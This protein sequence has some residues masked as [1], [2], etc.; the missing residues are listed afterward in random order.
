MTKADLSFVYK[1]IYIYLA[2]HSE[3]TKLNRDNRNHYPTT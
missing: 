3:R 1:F 2:A